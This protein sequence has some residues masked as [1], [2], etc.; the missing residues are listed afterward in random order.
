M[1]PGEGVNALMV[2]HGATDW[3]VQKRYLGRSDIPLNEAGR[4]QAEELG[5][6]LAAAGVFCEAVYTSPLR[7]AQETAELLR[8]MVNE[9]CPL[10]ADERLMETDFGDLDGLTYDEA[11]A[12]LGSRL[13]DWY[14][15]AETSAPPG[16]TESLSDVLARMRSF[17]SDVASSGYKN[18]LIVS[19]GGP[20]RAWLA[21]SRGEPFW[22]IAIEPGQYCECGII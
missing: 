9:E 2:R 10:I 6:R 20:I 5:N 19:H 16:G 15:H 13:T 14:D 8:S 1:K 17:M 12:K 18:V 11:L 21:F 3:N 22:D 4:K 7:R